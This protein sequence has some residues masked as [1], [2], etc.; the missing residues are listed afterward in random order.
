MIYSEQIE[1]DNATY[2]EFADKFKPKKT[3][4]DCYTPKAIY[5]VVEEYVCEKYGYNRDQFVRPFWP[6]GNY[7]SFDYPEN[8][9]VVDNPPFSICS[10]IVGFY[11]SNN[12]PF[13]LF[14]PG[15]TPFS[16]SKK[17]STI[18]C[19]GFGIIYE[20]GANVNTSFVT[21]M[22]GDEIVAKSEPKLYKL[23]KDAQTK[24]LKETKKE[25]PKY[26]FPDYIVTAAKLNYLSKYDTELEIHRS[27]SIAVSTID[28]MKAKGKNIFG[29]GFLLAEKAAA[30]KAAAEKAAAEKWQLSEREWEIVDYLSRKEKA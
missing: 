14:C 18:I 26:E 16:S 9:A 25:Q 30:E 7:E 8:C 24:S 28:A 17:H 13:F 5:S 20:N 21:N 23:L 15:L 2:K 6:G 11:E 29:K 22:E 3:T 1:F 10:Q 4:D 12:I 19:V 27:E